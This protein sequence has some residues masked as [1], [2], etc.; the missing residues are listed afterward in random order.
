M[1]RPPVGAENY[2][3]S[4]IQ[5]GHRLLVNDVASDQLDR[6]GSRRH[7]VDCLVDPSRAAEPLVTIPVVWRGDPDELSEPYASAIR[8]LEQRHG[9]ATQARSITRAISVT[10]RLL[11]VARAVRRG[12]TDVA[13]E[14]PGRGYVI[15]NVALDDAMRL[16]GGRYPRVMVASVVGVGLGTLL[17]LVGLGGAVLA[18][19]AH[20]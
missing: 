20:G 10:D 1:G 4:R 12:D 2:K 14:P 18:A 13:L 6:R 11:V 5:A 17:A 8:V 9:R 16:L 15:S 3:T 19:V 7:H